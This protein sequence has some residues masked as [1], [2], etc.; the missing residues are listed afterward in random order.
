MLV[1]GP[2][3]TA[4]RRSQQGGMGCR[5]RRNHGSLAC[6]SWFW[7]GMPSWSSAGPAGWGWLL[8]CSPVPGHSWQTHRAR[9]LSSHRDGAGDSWHAVGPHVMSKARAPATC[10]AGR[11]WPLAVSPTWVGGGP[12]LGALGFPCLPLQNVWGPQVCTLHHPSCSSPL[13]GNSCPH[14]TEPAGGSL[15]SLPHPAL[16]GVSSW[17]VHT[18]SGPGTAHLSMNSVQG[19]LDSASPH[20]WTWCS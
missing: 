18:A 10:D 16:P 15:Y 17:S 1:G 4:G 12:W 11:S 6:G 3:V 9:P 2:Q 13:Q 14:G 20:P 19:W 5:P 8:T 7:G